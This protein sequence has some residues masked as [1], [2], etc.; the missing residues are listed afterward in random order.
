MKKAQPPLPSPL[1]RLF[2]PRIFGGGERGAA[3]HDDPS[4]NC[5]L[6]TNTA[7]SPFRR[8]HLATHSALL[9]RRILPDHQQQLFLALVLHQLAE[10][11][12]AP[13]RHLIELRLAMHPRRRHAGGKREWNGHKCALHF[14]APTNFSNR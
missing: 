1:T 2:P 8:A 3:V 11:Q 6:S 7:L 9:A 5:I 4:G 10:R 13:G 12:P 14:I